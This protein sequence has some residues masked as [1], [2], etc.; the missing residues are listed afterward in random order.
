VVSNADLIKRL[1]D[2]PVMAWSPPILKQ[3]ADALEAHEWRTDMEN[4]PRDGT[5]IRAYF[6]D[7]AACEE[8]TGHHA[9]GQIDTY[10]AGCDTYG[11]WQTPGRTSTDEYKP[12]HWKPLDNPPDTQNT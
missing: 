6:P 5:W 9:P 8:R 3:A 11:R 1:R 7:W 12:T 4:A 10:W 2:Q